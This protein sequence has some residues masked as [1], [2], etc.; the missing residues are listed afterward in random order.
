LSYIP[1]YIWI[2]TSENE[3]LPTAETYI[4]SKTS[5][6]LTNSNIDFK[7]LMIATFAFRSDGKF[8][9]ARGRNFDND[10]T[11][12]EQ[13]MGNFELKTDT[14][15]FYNGEWYSGNTLDS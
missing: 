15:D 4:A 13:A 11:G 10:N 3:A 8:F 5:S 2:S 12:L 6:D 1:I 7:E 9:A 14:F